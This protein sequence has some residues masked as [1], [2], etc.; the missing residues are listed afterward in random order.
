MRYVI[1]LLLLAAATIAHGETLTASCKDPTG[2]ALGVLGKIGGGRAIDN[3]DSMKGG[4]VTL[5][6]KLNQSNA[7]IVIDTGAANSVSTTQGILFF[8]TEEQLSFVAS[9]PGAAYMYSVFPKAKRMLI[10]SHQLFLGM[11]SESA[12]GK[13]WFASCE[14]SIQ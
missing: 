4:L 8:Q 12:V 2:R 10:G 11:D 5:S 13:A 14:I 9:Y 6:W 7:T 1:P 3:P